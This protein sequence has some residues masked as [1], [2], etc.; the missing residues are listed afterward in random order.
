MALHANIKAGEIALTDG[1]FPQSAH[2]LF[3]THGAPNP[4]DYSGPQHQRTEDSQDET[5]GGRGATFTAAFGYVPAGSTV[6]RTFEVQECRL[7]AQCKEKPGSSR[8]HGTG[9]FAY[10][11]GDTRDPPFRGSIPRK[12]RDDE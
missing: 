11:V 10:L 8:W 5:R 7:C 6:R 3:R 2:E 4:H 12:P 9:N 1:R